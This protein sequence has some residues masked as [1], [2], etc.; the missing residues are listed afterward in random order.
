QPGFF[1]GCAAG[2]CVGSLVLVNRADYGFHQPWAVA[3]RHSAHAELF[4]Q[5]HLVALRVVRQHAHDIVTHKKLALDF[6]A[7]AASEQSMTQPEAI[8]VIETAETA[9]SLDNF[10]VIGPGFENLGHCTLTYRLFR[11]AK[12]HRKDIAVTA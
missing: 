9:I 7:H 4:D 1:H 5:Y 6:C 10:H 3:A 8:Q 12:R 2:H 11:D